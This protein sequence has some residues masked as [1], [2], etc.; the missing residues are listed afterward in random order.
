MKLTALT[1]SQEVDTMCNLSAGIYERGRLETLRNDVKNA[2]ESFHLS[3][4]D[5]MNGLK[6]TQEEQDIL[7]KMDWL[8][9][10]K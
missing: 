10:T 2:M 3:M 5:A 9:V 4:E 6:V 8:S 7:R 1:L